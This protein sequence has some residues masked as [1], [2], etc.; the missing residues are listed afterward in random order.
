MEQSTD[1][2]KPDPPPAGYTPVTGATLPYIP[3]EAMKPGLSK[4]RARLP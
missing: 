3:P 4:P 2:R 1:K